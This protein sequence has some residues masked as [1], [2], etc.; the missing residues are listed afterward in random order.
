[1]VCE[2]HDMVCEFHDVVLV[3]V[4][5][6]MVANFWLSSLVKNVKRQ[7]YE[8]DGVKVFVRHRDYDVFVVQVND[9]WFAE[10]VCVWRH[11]VMFEGSRVVKVAIAS[12]ACTSFAD[13][14]FAEDSAVPECLWPYLE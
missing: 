2:F 10:E 13:W 12:M 6:V 7:V 1:M 14:A 8:G 4:D 9:V 5:G 3:Q 11:G